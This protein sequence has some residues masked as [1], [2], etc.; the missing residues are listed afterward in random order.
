MINVCWF[1]IFQKH[2]DYMELDEFINIFS[3]LY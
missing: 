2:H 3:I 1:E